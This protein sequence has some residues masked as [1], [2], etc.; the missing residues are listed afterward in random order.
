MADPYAYGFTAKLAKPCLMEDLQKTVAG[1]AL[2]GEAGLR[3]A[4]RAEM[5]PA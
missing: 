5:P 2:R 3:R 4:G 1:I